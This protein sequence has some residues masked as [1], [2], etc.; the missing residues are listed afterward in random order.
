[1]PDSINKSYSNTFQLIDLTNH[2]IMFR[3][4]IR[5]TKHATTPTIHFPAVNDKLYHDTQKTP[6]N[7]FLRR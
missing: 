7:Q 4:T 6:Q 3:I 1:M 5:S 2:C